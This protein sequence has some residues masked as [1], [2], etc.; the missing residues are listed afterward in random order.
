MNQPDSTD[1]LG[2]YLRA[3]RESRGGSIEEMARATRI[4]GSR[5]QALER[6]QFSELPAPVFIKGFIRAYCEF[7]GAKPDEALA[8][9]QR[10]L[11]E[12]IATPADRAT[13]R[14]VNLRRRRWSWSPI[15]TS[16]VL[17]LLFGFGLIGL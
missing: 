6:E 15:V 13:L 11:G 14:A 1:S 4:G 12:P 16:L 3:L 5:L 9:Y 2:P 10:M 7:L 8:R 17:L